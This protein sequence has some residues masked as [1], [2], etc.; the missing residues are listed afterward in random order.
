MA[1]A[2]PGALHACP[3]GAVHGW[4]A[5][6]FPS[7]HRPAGHGDPQYQPGG[8]VELQV[9]GVTVPSLLHAEFAGQLAQVAV[10]PLE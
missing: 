8:W 3:G 6:P 4:H 5:G 1:F 2:E 7:D 10:P 9:C